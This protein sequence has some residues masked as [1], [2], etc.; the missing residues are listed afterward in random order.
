[1][2]AYHDKAAMPYERFIQLGPES[3]TDG[4]LL[5]IILRTGTRDKNALEL[6]D[7]I[8]KLQDNMQGKLIGL[9]HLSL[10]QL[11]KLPGIGEVK[12]VKI[13]AI[14]ELAKRMAKQSARNEIVFLNAQQIA[15]YYME[16]MRHNTEECVLLVML[17]NKGHLMGQRQIS[18]GTVNASLVS[19]RE[20]F[21][22][23]LKYE[24]S[25][26]VLLHN[27]PSGDATPSVSDRIF[28]KQINDSSKLMNIPLID[29][30]IIGD[31]TYSSFKEL[32]YI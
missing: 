25:S 6:A 2:T 21:M 18:K 15:E 8:L 16:S 23:A 22:M 32:G 24:A 10:E 3:L 30:I 11:K 19:P 14:A 4:E 7:D 12:A 31:H 26:I 29:H 9:H 1:M 5:A 27:H 20:V 28:T 17:D 13:K